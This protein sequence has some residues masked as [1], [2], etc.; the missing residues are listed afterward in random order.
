MVK[1]FVELKN[2]CKV[3]LC[4]CWLKKI[5]FEKKY[6]TVISN[7][8]IYFGLQWLTTTAEVFRLVIVETGV[9]NEYSYVLKG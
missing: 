6:I 1:T 4:K 2:I 7:P 5:K 9:I 3:V 8:V